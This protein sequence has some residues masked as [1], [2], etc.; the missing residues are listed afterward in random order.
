MLTGWL[1][2][3]IGMV[4]ILQNFDGDLSW[5]GPACAV[6]I[7]TLFCAL[8]LKLVLWVPLEAWLTEQAH[9]ER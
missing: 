3:M 6:M 9:Q 5:M 7:L 8:F 4:Q 2:M 1:A